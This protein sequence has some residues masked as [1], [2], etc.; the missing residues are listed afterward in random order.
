[1][2]QL[3]FQSEPVAW[4][5]LNKFCL[6]VLAAA[7]FDPA[8]ARTVADSL[9]QANLSGWDSHGVARLPHY[10]RRV[11]QG[12]INPRPTISFE[13]LGPAAA[14]VD[15][16]HGMGH[17]VMTRA[18]EHAVEQAKSAGASWVSVCNS[19]HCGTL[20]YFGH[21]IAEAGMIGFA[22]THVDPMVVPFGSTEAFCGTNPICITAPGRE[23]KV[24]CLDMATSVTPWNSI[25]N[26]A[27]EGVGIPAGWA[28][29][30]SGNETL[31]PNQVRAIN[32]M[33]GYKGS[34]LGLMIDVLCA[35]L[36]DSP[37]GPDIPK[38]YGDLS[39]HRRLG[40]LVG[41]INI[42]SFVGLDR[43]QHRISE[44]LQRWGALNP[45]QDGERVLYPGEPEEINR[46]QRLDQGIPLGLQ[47]IDQFNE[48]AA[49]MQVRPL[50]LLST[51]N[52]GGK[53]VA[54]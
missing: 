6:D 3:S 35:M 8:G 31:D 23:G 54:S 5:H 11:K 17:V 44:M 37:Y 14:R 36:S 2:P 16:N 1:M 20:S 28:V 15:G 50:R 45:S 34:G 19:S 29:D 9:T 7:G 42:E 33:A 52:S 48:I 38:M 53:A 4:E 39:Q 47:L 32:P 43:F 26:A 46:K 22:F 12:S 51:E 30:E 18:A 25:E 40:G 21:K 41:A 10:L 13:L 27:I 24:L 49:R